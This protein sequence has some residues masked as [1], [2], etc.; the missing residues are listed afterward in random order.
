MLAPEKKGLAPEL[1]LVLSTPVVTGN[2]L[3]G[4][5]LIS[6]KGK[7]FFSTPQHPDQPWG[8]SSFLSK[9]H[10]GA[11]FLEVKQPGHEGD[12]SLL[13][14]AEVKNGGVI[15]SLPHIPWHGA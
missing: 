14:S 4:Q 5:G 7:R 11:L 12:H 13:C 3:D 6:R 2:R 9:G 15:P 10:G 1:F 8:P